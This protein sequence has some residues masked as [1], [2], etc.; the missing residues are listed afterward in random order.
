MWAGLQDDSPLRAD[1]FLVQGAS[2]WQVI[3]PDRLGPVPPGWKLDR[4]HDEERRGAGDGDWTEPTR[5][6]W[7][8]PEPTWAG[9]R[10]GSHC[11]VLGQSEPARSQTGSQLITQEASGQVTWS[12]RQE[13]IPTQDR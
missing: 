13:P 9:S 6:T 8:C 1:W 3:G 12:G 5:T 11:R 7:T 4:V 10:T 2:C